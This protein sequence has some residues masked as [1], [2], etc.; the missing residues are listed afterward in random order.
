MV[1]RIGGQTAE[2]MRLMNC[3]LRCEARVVEFPERS[4]LADKPLIHSMQAAGK[5]KRTLISRFQ[6]LKAI[7]SFAAGGR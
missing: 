1:G 3:I 7:C 4:G 5:R 2:S 6:P